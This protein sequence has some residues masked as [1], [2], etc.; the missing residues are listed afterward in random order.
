VAGEIVH[1]D[2]VAGLK[3]GHEHLGDIGFEGI[4]V[5]RPVQH[6]RRN[7]AARRQRADEG[8]GFP[9]PMG[10]ADLQPLATQAASMTAR[11]VGRGPRLVD[12][13]Q[14]VGIEVELILEPS[15]ALDQDVRAVLFGGVR[16]LFYA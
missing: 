15:F 6:P 13:H 7:E 1:D 5:D 8:R 10:D 4:P 12:K 16:G 2:D 9:M 3:F 11:H 14:R